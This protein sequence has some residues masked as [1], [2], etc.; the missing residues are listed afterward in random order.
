MKS[1]HPPK[2]LIPIFFKKKSIW[3]RI[4]VQTKYYFP[5]FPGIACKSYGVK[6]SPS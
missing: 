4:R 2:E 5:R 3:V 1:L 6:I